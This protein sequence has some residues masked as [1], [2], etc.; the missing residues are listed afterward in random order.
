MRRVQGE[1]VTARR[2]AGDRRELRRI[3]VVGQTHRVYRDAGVPQ[4]LRGTAS[5]RVRVPVGYVNDD[6]VDTGTITV[7]RCEL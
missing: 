3:R 6:V 2:G 4:L 5:W 1:R 7:G